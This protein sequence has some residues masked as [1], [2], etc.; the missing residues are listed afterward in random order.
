MFRSYYRVSVRILIL[1]HCTLYAA[2]FNTTPR[3]CTY[4]CTCICIRSSE[5]PIWW[6]SDGG[7]RGPCRLT[8]LTVLSMYKYLYKYKYSVQ[9]IPC[10]ILLCLYTYQC[11]SVKRYMSL[12]P[13]NLRRSIMPLSPIRSSI[14]I[15]HS[16]LVKY[17]KHPEHP[18]RNT[19]R[20]CAAEPSI[21]A[22][23]YDT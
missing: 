5:R 6:G 4:T 13:H 2:L 12:S 11:N 23:G 10:N 21:P 16:V 8:H 15:T 14:A 22:S 3:S 20:Q 19:K 18:N 1:V 17:R 9:Y 7:S